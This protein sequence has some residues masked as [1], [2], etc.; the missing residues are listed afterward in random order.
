[1]AKKPLPNKK[2]QLPSK[3]QPTPNPKPRPNLPHNL[4]SPISRQHNL[5]Q[6]VTSSGYVTKSWRSPPKKCKNSQTWPY[7]AEI[8]AQNLQRNAFS[9]TIEIAFHGFYNFPICKRR[10]DKRYDSRGIY[11][12]GH[13][14]GQIF[15]IEVNFSYCCM[16]EPAKRCTRFLP[17]L[18]KNRVFK[19]CTL[20]SYPEGGNNYDVMVITGC[21]S[22]AF[23]FRR[24]GREWSIQNCDVKEPY[25][26]SQTM[27]FSN[28]IGFKGKFYAL[29]LQGSLVVIED[30]EDHW[31]ITAI[32]KN[33]AVPTKVSRQFRECLVK[34][35]GEILLVLL[36]SR[37]CIDV[38]DDVEVFRLDFE[39]LLWV[40]VES[41]GDKALVVEDEC[42]MWVDARM[43]GCKKNCVYFRVD[44][45]WRFDMESGR[46]EEAFGNGSKEVVMFGEVMEMG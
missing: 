7:L 30:I 23:G 4:I 3:N 8:N 31:D 22:P 29:S 14:N 1:M 17:S 38:V 28:A 40:K 42:C 41:L 9:H 26:P 33:R 20:S 12:E 16:S 44:N 39:K 37:K 43:V 27:S 19:S 34:C 35:N 5:M 2:K 36:I 15:A 45:W 46:I 10:S 13:S 11:F 21:S 6:N 25:F 32:G 18:D 24:L